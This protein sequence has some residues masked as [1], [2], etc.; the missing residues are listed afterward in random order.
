V[1]IQ[2]SPNEILEGKKVS[3]EL[4]DVARELFGIYL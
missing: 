4:A 2:E 1:L 3:D